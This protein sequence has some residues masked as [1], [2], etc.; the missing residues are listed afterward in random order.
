[1]FKYYTRTLGICFLFLCSSSW[2][3]ELKSIKDVENSLSPVN[4]FKGD[5]LWN[6]QDRMKHYGVPGVG[7]AVIKDYKISWFKTYGLADR[8]TG[9]TASNQ[10]LFQ[11]GSVSKP[12]AAFAALRLVEAGKLSLDADINTVLKSWQ[13]PENQFTTKNKVTLRQLLS[14]TGGLTVHG[15][16]GYSVG[17]KVPNVI[18]VLNGA[19]PANSSPVRVNKEPGGDFRYSGGGYTIAQLMMSDVS[20][21]PFEKVMDDL[22]IRPSQM[23]QSTYQQPLPPT[24]LKYAASGVLPHGDAVTGKR[25][26]YPEMAAAGLWTT[27]GD[28]ASFAIEIQKALNGDSKLMSK[29]MAQTMTTEVDS[30]YALGWGINNRGASGYFSHGGWDEGFC[31]QLTG[32]LKDGYGVAIMINS[33][34]P[35]FLDEVVN[36]VGLTYGWDGYQA[37]VKQSIAKDVTNKYVGQYGYDSTRSI[38]ITSQAGKLW[39]SYPGTSPQE[40]NYTGEGIFLRRES[41][42]PIQFTE[43]KKAIQLNFVRSDGKYQSHSQMAVGEQMAGDILD[44]G[45]YADALIAYRAVRKA[46]SNE[47]SFSEGFLNRQGLN[48]MTDNSDYAI[49][50]LTINTDL[51]SE[52]ANTWDSL[53]LAYQQAGNQQ[54]A[55]EHYRN[56]LKRDPKFP[57]ALKALMELKK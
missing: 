51:Y 53:A 10:T 40:L 4:I 42:S 55:I 39:M 52:S 41:T 11:A 47:E 43:S 16:R 37:K 29:S 20:G 14:H 1:M 23:T 44:T 50:L 7:I 31:T 49:K 24:L 6:L 33:N 2:A 34:H 56:A 27:A 21:K 8:E 45:S 22:L 28:L 48:I 9:E 17:E 13:L 15:F 19:K 26:T 25:H 3:N 46:D 5:K 18:Q 12:A 54:K 57:S 32:H 30:G 35:E 36:A 38:S